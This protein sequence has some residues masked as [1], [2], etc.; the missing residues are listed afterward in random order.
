M[1]FR[2]MVVGHCIRE[3]A[4]LC[5]VILAAFTNGDGR[6]GEVES[7]GGTICVCASV[8]YVRMSVVYLLCGV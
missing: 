6:G 4:L 2:L 5:I 1:V 3:R 7:R 8:I